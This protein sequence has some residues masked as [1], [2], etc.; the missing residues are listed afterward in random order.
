MIKKQKRREAWNKGLKGIH[1]SPSTEFKKGSHTNKGR[2]FSEEHRKKI[3]INKKREWSNKENHPMYGKKHSEESKRKMSESRNK[4]IKE[5]KITIWSKG[6]TR[7]DLLGENNPSKRQDVRKKISENRK[8]FKHS[9]ETKK[10]FSENMKKKWANGELDHVIKAL[11][12]VRYKTQ[13]TKEK[14]K[15][16]VFPK[17]DTSIELKIQCLLRELNIEFYTHQYMEEIE[18]SYQCD[19]FVPSLK[20]VIE[21]DGDYWHKYPI[22]TDIDHIRTKELKDKGFNILRLWEHEIRGINKEELKIK[23]EE[24]KNDC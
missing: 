24:I 4:N 11:E 6:K 12:K 13:I 7:K 3:S 1:L 22:G 23:I 21:C 14:R 20:L 2:I 8:G 17:E 9:E 5:G 18:H 16:M 19:I 10:V 15:N